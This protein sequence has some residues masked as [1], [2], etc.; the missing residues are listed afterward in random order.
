MGTNKNERENKLPRRVRIANRFDGAVTYGS[1]DADFLVETIE[2]VAA[3]GGALRFGKTRDG[4]GLAIGIYGDGSPYTLYCGPGD[5]LS[6]VLSAI[7]AGFVTAPK[8]SDRVG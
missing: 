4:T 3:A 6:E 1:V 8:G 7:R 2:C 5:S